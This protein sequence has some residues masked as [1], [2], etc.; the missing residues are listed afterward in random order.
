VA[1]KISYD[2]K[3]ARPLIAHVEAGLRSFDRSMPEEMNRIVTDH[4]SDLLFV[5][6][7]SGMRNL[8][9]EGVAREKVYFVG[10]TMIDSLLAYREKAKSSTILHD[11]GLRNGVDNNLPGRLMAPYALLTLHR[12]AN[13]D[14]RDAFLKILGGLEDATREFPVVFPA[15][16][17]TQKR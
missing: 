7:E 1:S 11:L 6:E 8:A 5:T 12:P 9:R 4:L 15:H 10:N 3:G 17:R 16:P 13:V 2:S 14:S